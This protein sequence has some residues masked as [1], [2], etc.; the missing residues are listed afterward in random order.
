MTIR[1]VGLRNRSFEEGELEDI[2]VVQGHSSD[3]VE[4]RELKG[5]IIHGGPPL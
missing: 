4:D 3:E 2:E 5:P 1:A